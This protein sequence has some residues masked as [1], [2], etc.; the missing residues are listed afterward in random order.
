M[1]VLHV[2]IRE[3]KARLS[4]YLA[5]PQAGQTMTCLRKLSNWLARSQRRSRCG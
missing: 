5:E 2:P 4:H 1:G 3:F